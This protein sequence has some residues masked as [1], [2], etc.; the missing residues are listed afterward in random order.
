LQQHAG[1]RP[2]APCLRP[3]LPVSAVRRLE[4]GTKAWW[5]GHGS[6]QEQGTGILVGWTRDSAGA[7]HRDFGGLDTGLCRSRAPGFWWA[8]HG[9]LQEQ[10]TGILVGWT[11][12]SVTGQ[13]QPSLR[14]E[15]SPFPGSLLSMMSFCPSILP[16]FL[17]SFR[18]SAWP[19]LT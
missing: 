7:G 19:L 16:A 2:P 4:Q 1:L 5:A 11:R 14:P 10:G 17:L 13:K 8:G 15:A 12:D 6:P 9:T 3:L 18:P